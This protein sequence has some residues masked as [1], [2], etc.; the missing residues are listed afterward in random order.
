MGLNTAAGAV[1]A[2]GTTAT[3][4]STDTYTTVGSVSNI[5]EF[6]RSYN[7][8]KFMPLATRGTKKVKGSYDEGSL[9]VELGRDTTDAGQAAVLVARDVDADYNFKV[10]PNDSNPAVSSVVTMT[11]AAPGVITWTANGLPVNTPASFSTTGALPTGLTAATTYFIKTILDANTF[12]V[13]ATAGGAAITT[14]GSQSGVHTATTVPAAS[15][16]LFKAQVAS[17]TTSI[18]TI[19][20]VMTRKMNL[21]IQ[22]GTLTETARIP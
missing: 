19:D 6:G 16:I 3:V 13:S 10:T 11:I 1:I 17:F 4:G 22:G 14:T 15:F 20:N 9:M 2:I 8:V 5:P 7:E 21:L 12:T 18:G